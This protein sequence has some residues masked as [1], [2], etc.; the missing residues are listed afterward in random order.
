[1]GIWQKMLTWAQST[2]VLVDQRA[3]CSP[4]TS[5]TSKA[6]LLAAALCTILALKYP[7]TPQTGAFF[8]VTSC[9]THALNK[10]T[11]W[12]AVIGFSLTQRGSL[13][14]T[15]AQRVTAALTRGRIPSVTVPPRPPR[16]LRQT[17][18]QH[19]GLQLPA[20]RALLRTTLPGVPG[21]GAGVALCGGAGWAL[22]GVAGRA[23]CGGTRAGR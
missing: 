1:M 12:W 8:P 4:T 10:T 18:P 2:P 6:P 16:P 22:L 23:A 19:P 17:S 11:N 21:S 14:P 9:D 3:P 13:A 20:C 15:R 5:S 7:N